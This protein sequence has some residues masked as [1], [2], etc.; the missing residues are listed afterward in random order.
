MP[1]LRV[2]DEVE[3][4]NHRARDATRE[5]VG[6]LRLDLNPALIHFISGH[7]PPLTA[8]LPYFL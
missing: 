1:C 4:I 6:N 5:V 3:W 7:A 8:Q 2:L